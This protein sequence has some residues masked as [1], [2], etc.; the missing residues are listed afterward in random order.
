MKIFDFNIHLPYK[1][2]DNV[3]EL[4]KQDL[5]LDLASISYG[6]NIY[7]DDFK[8]LNGGNIQLFNTRLLDGNISSLRQELAS[9]FEGFYTTLLIDFRRSDIIEYLHLAK[10]AGITAIMFNSYLQKIGDEDFIE[11][12][13]ACKVAS[14]LNFII[15][16]DAS[17]GTSKMF[18][19]NNIKLACFIADG[20]SETPIVI[21]HSGGYNII[22]AMWLALDKK[23]IWLDTS[24]SLPCYIGS[25][26]EQ[27][28]A[29][30][31]K[32]LNYKRIVF[33]S[34]HP[35][36]QLD[37]TIEIH[38]SFF[39]KH[40]FPAIAIEDIFYNNASLLFNRSM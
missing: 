3:N 11:V 31:Y 23:N 10:N 33:G 20:I 29:F 7:Q 40:S 17:Y 32:K 36:M 21:V 4:I 38:R 19:Y 1:E 14:D 16:I 13:K 26:L 35:Y 34:D 2:A 9:H 12:Y 25:S 6:L 30:A 37:N 8:G 39:E 28:F 22:P 27:D 5:N 15:C 18:S 24:F